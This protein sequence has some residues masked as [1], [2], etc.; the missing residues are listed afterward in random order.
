MSARAL[1]FLAL[2]L[3]APPLRGGEP[4]EAPNPEPPPPGPAREKAVALTPRRG[5]L[6]SRINPPAA[7]SVFGWGAME[8]A[9][10]RG[11]PALLRTVP[12]E[13]AVQPSV[14][15]FTVTSRQATS[16]L[17][18]FPLVLV[19]GR[20]VYQDELEMAQGGRG[21]TARD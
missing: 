21:L 11:S 9:A 7:G 8:G 14:R 17:S 6:T 16:A 13:N 12:G 3:P 19:D 2:L 4:P 1:A 15:D 10:G 5:R 20:W 18:H